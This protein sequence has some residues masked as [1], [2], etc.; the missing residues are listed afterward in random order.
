VLQL[1]YGRSDEHLHQFQ[2][3]G[4]EY[5]IHREGGIW[6][7]SGLGADEERCS[8]LEFLTA[9]TARRNTN[10]RGSDTPRCGAQPCGTTRSDDCGSPGPC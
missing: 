8:N 6:N 5:G 9:G 7:G 4:C 10:E 2:I 3:H 1:L